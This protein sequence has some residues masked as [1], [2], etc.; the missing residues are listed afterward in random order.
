MMNVGATSPNALEELPIPITVSS[1]G[2]TTFVWSLCSKSTCSI[3]RVS[4]VVTI[5]SLANVV[6]PGRA[7]GV[8][9]NHAELLLSLIATGKIRGLKLGVNG[10]RGN[11]DKMTEPEAI[12]EADG[13]HLPP[14]N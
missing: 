8:G 3:C 1:M 11:D 14:S 5:C 2:D 7:V 13:S 4:G 6:G 10:S 12:H 9:E